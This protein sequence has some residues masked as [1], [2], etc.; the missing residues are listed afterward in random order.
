MSKRHDEKDR[1]IEIVRNFYDKLTD[2][3]QRTICMLLSRKVPESRICK[4]LGTN[5]KKL[6]L[7]KVQIAVGLRQSG[8]EI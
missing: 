2:E 8:L 5:A 7:I 1:R 3:N 6:E 4:L